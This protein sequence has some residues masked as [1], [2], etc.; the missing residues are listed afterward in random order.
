MIDVLGSVYD[1]LKAYIQPEPE[2]IIVGWQNHAALPKDSSSYIVLALLDTRRE[3]T[4]VHEWAAAADSDTDITNGIKM[5]TL[6]DVQIDFCGTDERE[7]N[8]QAVQCALL[9][10]DA[11]GVNF[12]Q[13]QG[14]SCL[15]ADDLRALPFSNDLKQWEVRYSVTLHLSAW[16][17]YTL[18]QEAFTTVEARIENVDMHHKP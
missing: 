7:V 17:T 15:Y 6:Y 11:A 3:G 10:R 12:F 4:N 2:N 16:N 14:L 5:L 18:T 9:G 13:T 1:F 8:A